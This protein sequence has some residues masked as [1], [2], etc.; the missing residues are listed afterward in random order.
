MPKIKTRK[1]AAKRV[2]ITAKGHVTH[3][4]ASRA[5]KLTKK[6]ATRK[7]AY[8]LDHRAS[9]TDEKNLKKMLGGS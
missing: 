9:A 5:H 4:R 2:K 1:S 8:T 3:L 6:S 7:R